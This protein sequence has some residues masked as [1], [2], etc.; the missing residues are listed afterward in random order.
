MLSDV[1]LLAAI[2]ENECQRNL[3]FVKK[4][5]VFENFFEIFIKCIIPE[6]NISWNTFLLYQPF[7]YSPQF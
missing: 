6:K 3:L 2:K 7:K 5:N 4:E 1:C